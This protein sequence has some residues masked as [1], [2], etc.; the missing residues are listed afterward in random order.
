MINLPS[1]EANEL[2]NLLLQSGTALIKAG[3]GSNRVV[4]NVM[5][6]AGAY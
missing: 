5:R 3:A 2:G 1:T 6:L 4:V